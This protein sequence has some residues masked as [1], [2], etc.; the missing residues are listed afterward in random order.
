MKNIINLFCTLICCFSSLT[1]AEIVPVWSVDVALPGEKVVLYLVDTDVGEDLFMIQKRPTVQNAGLEILQHYAGANP[2]D[3]NRAAMEVYPLQIT[4]DAAGE[5]R[6]SALEVKYNSGRT[7]TIEVPALPVVSTSAIRWSKDPVSFG[8]LW[9]TDIKEGYVHQP[10]KTA[11]KLLLPG[12]ID[13]VG[14]PQLN[15][16]DVRVGS[17]QPTL[18]GVLAMIHNQAIGTTTAYAKNKN[19]R[20]VDFTGTLTPFREGNSDVAGKIILEQRQGFFSLMRAEAELPVLTLFSKRPLEV[21]LK[22]VVRA[23]AYPENIE[24]V[25]LQ[26][27]AELPVSVWKIR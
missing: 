5:V 23:V 20:T 12:G 17:F 10:V 7:E 27:V 3:P 18:Q 19:W 15:S 4:P 6:V 8:V 26:A 16:V 13:P 14:T 2:M 25:P 11:V 24:S 21:R 22:T 9:H 1:L